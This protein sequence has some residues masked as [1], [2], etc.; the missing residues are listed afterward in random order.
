MKQKDIAM[1]VLVVG[2][3][4]M[5][6]YF[7]ASRFIVPAKNRSTKVEVV[8]KINSNFTEPNQNYFNGNSI[9]PTQTITIGEDGNPKPFSER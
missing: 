6:S 7:M 4:G 5:L 9:N 3:S 1:I 2:I 8:G